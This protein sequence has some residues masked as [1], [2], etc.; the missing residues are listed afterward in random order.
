MSSWLTRLLV[1][2]AGLLLA[3]TTAE[4]FAPGV[5]KARKGYGGY[6]GRGYHYCNYAC[7]K[8]KYA[9]VCHVSCGR[10]SR[11][12]VFCAKQDLKELKVGCAQTRA[13]A[14]ADCTDASCKKQAKTVFR[15]CTQQIKSQVAALKATCRQGTTQC[16]GCCRQ[17]P[18][19]SCTSAFSDTP[20][21][22]TSSRTSRSYGHT[23]RS[24]PDCSAAAGRKG[25]PPGAFVDYTAS[26]RTWFF[27]LLWRVVPL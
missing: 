26:F 27:E 6:G 10:A 7:Q 13:A 1:L 21:Y 9:K 20:G 16:G 2:M 22:G 24:R 11:T 12:C 17:S 25:S 23:Y 3:L 14:L 19:G 5:A 4:S 18:Q 8:R 15:G